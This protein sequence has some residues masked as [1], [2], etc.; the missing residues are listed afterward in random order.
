MAD[1]NTAFK[2]TDNIEGEYANNP[3][4]RGGETYKG[5]ARKK[6]HEW[7]GWRLIDSIKARM[8]KQPAYGTSEYRSW[9][10]HLNSLLRDSVSV[11]A[12]VKE[13]YL[14]LFWRNLGK[15]EN[16]ELANWVYD[17]DVN[18]GSRGSRWLQQALGVKV[19]GVVGPQTIA[20]ANS[21]SDPDDLLDHMKAL[22][23]Q[24]Y[25]QVAEND[26]TQQQFLKGWLA[27]V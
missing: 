27:R 10:K 11:Q 20:A 19:D 2:A 15:L 1:F 17:K 16:Q 23:R 22:A 13:F 21:V 14:T 5:I 26:P 9:V 25:T 12:K 7:V 3:A 6:H 18:T 24:Y 4:D 8:V